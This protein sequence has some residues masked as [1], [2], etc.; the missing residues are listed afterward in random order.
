MTIDGAVAAA[1]A[2]IP[3]SADAR[4]YVALNMVESVDG[5]VTVGER[6][7]GLTSPQ[8]Q[9]LLYAL[10]E[11]ADV[12]VVGATTVRAEGYGRLLP[13]EHR[14]RRV[15]N[16]RG[17][18]PILC[19][20]TRLRG[21]PTGSPA[22]TA[23]HRVIVATGA[24]REILEDAPGVEYLRYSTPDYSTPLAQLLED[25]RKRFGAQTCV[26]EGGPE[27][28]REFIDA[29]LCDEIFVAISPRIVG[30]AGRAGVFAPVRDLH[31]LEL[32]SVLRAN[33]HMFLRYGVA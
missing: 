5:R 21:L 9:E 17:P 16:G 23:E 28:A 12:V 22:L 32:R 18:E 29:R 20:L 19:V 15:E 30:L 3:R 11:Q 33:G 1:H 10:R 4:P 6:V 27:V 13:D 8:D 26:C 31:E 24:S 2:Q 7:G 14:R 25:L